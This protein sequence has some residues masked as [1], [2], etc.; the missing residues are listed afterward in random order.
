MEAFIGRA[1]D[2]YSSRAFAY[3][4][5]EKNFLWEMLDTDRNICGQI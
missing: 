4:C 1:I 5:G 2:F 3:L